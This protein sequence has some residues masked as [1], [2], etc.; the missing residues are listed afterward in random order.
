MGIGSVNYGSGNPYPWGPPVPDLAMNVN[1]L[2]GIW[3]QAKEG[4]DRAAN[5]RAFAALSQAR[6]T[7]ELRG[8]LAGLQQQRSSRPWYQSFNPLADSGFATPAENS[9]MG[10]LVKDA[11]RDPLD[12]A[13]RR[14][15]IAN[16]QAEYDPASPLY[17]AK[18][19]SYEALG[20]QRTASANQTNTLTPYRVQDL[21]SRTAY[22]EAQTD[23]IYYLTPIEAAEREA[24]TGLKLAQATEA[25]SRTTLNQGRAQDLDAKNHSGFWGATVDKLKAGIA[26]LKAR[27]ETADALRSGQLEEQKNRNNLLLQQA[28]L[29]GENAARVQA[30]AYRVRLGLIPSDLEIQRERE[31]YDKQIADLKNSM[32]KI[33]ASNPQ[34]DVNSLEQAINETYGA[35]ATFE[36]DAQ[37]W[38]ANRPKSATTAPAPSTTV[39]PT[40]DAQGMY[41]VSGPEEG[42]KLKA[43]G[44]PANKIYW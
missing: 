22:K 3:N 28:R 10:G 2:L 32:A 13:Y 4:A 19:K 31:K 8:A 29:A 37:G 40:P 17:Q 26:N 1:A 6:N 33:K 25:N 39:Q 44:I 11:F 34:A 20:D 16:L 9:A 5:D 24:A 36:K 14:A 18:V 35:K 7:E 23:K 38:V 27:T 15:Q 41:K 30:M 42:M 12:D 43:Q 21:Q